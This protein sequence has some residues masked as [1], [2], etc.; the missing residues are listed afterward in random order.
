MQSKQSSVIE[1]GQDTWT[2][3]LCGH[4]TGPTKPGR[5]PVSSSRDRRRGPGPGAYGARH[6]AYQQRPTPAINASK[7]G[8]RSC[9]CIVLPALEDWRINF[10]SFTY[11]PHTNDDISPAIF[12]HH[13]QVL[14]VC[15]WC[16][17]L[18]AHQVSAS[19]H[20]RSIANNSFLT[21]TAAA[22]SSAALTA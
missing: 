20:S 15:V 16:E 6:R 8:D 22:T 9:S 13:H 21:M 5:S 10:P 2:A 3:A 17:R 4:L 1:V 12:R 11:F 19:A 7:G 14:L 18:S